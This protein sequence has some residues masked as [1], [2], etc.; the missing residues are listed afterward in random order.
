M[1]YDPLSSLSSRVCMLYWGVS[2]LTNIKHNSTMTANANFLLFTF[3]C[4]SRSSKSF[5]KRTFTE[6]VFRFSS[7]VVVMFQKQFFLWLYLS[8][9][10]V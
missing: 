5:P 3:F 7:V 10:S 8:N 6:K 9:V 1:V 2:G 4:H